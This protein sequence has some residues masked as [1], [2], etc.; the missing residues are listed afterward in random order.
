M[1][2]APYAMNKAEK[3]FDRNITIY[4]TTLGWRFPNPIMEKMYGLDSMAETAENLAQEDVYKR[5][6]IDTNHS[7]M[8]NNVC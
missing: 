2:R 6:V 5:Q 8:Q 7:G 1:S 3:A 4:D